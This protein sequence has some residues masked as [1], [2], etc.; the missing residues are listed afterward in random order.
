MDSFLEEQGIKVESNWI[1]EQDN[2]Y[3]TSIAPSDHR[4]S[5]YDYDESTF[6]DGI[7]SNTRVAMGDT[8]N[9]TLTKGSSANESGNGKGGQQVRLIPLD[10]SGK[11]NGLRDTF[12]YRFA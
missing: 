9:I 8:W 6:T 11:A 7:D 1:Y 3:I 10:G 12:G 5:T 2:N 4:L